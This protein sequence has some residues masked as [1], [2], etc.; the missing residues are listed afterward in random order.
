MHA[1]LV[2]NPRPKQASEHFL[3]QIGLCF[4]TRYGEL[5]KPKANRPVRKRTVRGSAAGFPVL[6]E[7]KA[8]RFASE[9][10][11]CFASEQPS[12]PSPPKGGQ[13]P[14]QQV[15]TISRVAQCA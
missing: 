10:F 9:P 7:A 5:K 2:S 8:L 6:S 4:A 12:V 1:N 15:E 13:A 14:H 3:L 11:A